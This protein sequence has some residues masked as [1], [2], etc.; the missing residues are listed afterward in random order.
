M[1][2]CM[3][4]IVTIGTRSVHLPLLA[5]GDGREFPLDGPD[6]GRPGDGRAGGIGSNPAAST[7]HYLVNAVFRADH[8]AL[9]DWH[10]FYYHRLQ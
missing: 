6:V 4:Q 1:R 3:S 2:C 9:K 10:S 7:T 5:S 8:V